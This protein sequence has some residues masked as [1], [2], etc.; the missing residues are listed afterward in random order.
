MTRHAIGQAIRDIRAGKL[1]R[2]AR[3]HP[4]FD[5]WAIL[6][7]GVEVRFVPSF[8]KGHWEL[9]GPAGREIPGASPTTLIEATR[10]I[11][12]LACYA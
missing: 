2:G 12:V 7:N 1:P 11:E 8:P 3:W 4:D 10:H 5:S 9:L 6:P